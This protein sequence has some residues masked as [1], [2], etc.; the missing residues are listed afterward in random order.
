VLFALLVSAILADALAVNWLV[1]NDVPSR[2][3]CRFAE[4]VAALHPGEIQVPPACPRG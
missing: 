3:V 1:T 4:Q 2:Q